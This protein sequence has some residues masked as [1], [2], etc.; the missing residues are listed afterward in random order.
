MNEHWGR[1]QSVLYNGN[2]HQY[3]CHSIS[4]EACG[5]MVS[6]KQAISSFFLLLEHGIGTAIS[7]IFV[8]HRADT[9]LD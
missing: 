4:A 6:V 3:V 7:F 1:I 2:F 5:A 9:L 8:R